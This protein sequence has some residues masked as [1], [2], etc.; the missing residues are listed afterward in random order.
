MRILNELGRS[1]LIEREG[2]YLNPYKCPAGVWTIGIGTTVY[3]NGA[4]VS[5]NDTCITK[6]KAYEY[7][8]W[9]LSLKSSTL[10]HFLK[11]NNLVFTDNQFSALLSFA[12]NL[13]CGPIIDNHRSLCQALI[14][15][16]G[17]REAF[18]LYVKARNRFGFMVKLK[19]LITRRTQEADL[20]ELN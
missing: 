3:P 10:E 2:L 12:Y 5:K 6:E 17:I 11:A 18:M 15:G 4:K 13:G 20:Y 9:E 19:G 8:D 7:L 1:L 16:K 14:L